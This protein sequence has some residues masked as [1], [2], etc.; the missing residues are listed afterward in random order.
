[1]NRHGFVYSLLIL[2]HLLVSCCKV[3]HIILE[4]YTNEA[5]EI[6]ELY[7]ELLLARFGL[8]EQMRY[9]QR[10]FDSFF[11]TRVGIVTL[12]LPKQ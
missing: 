3:E 4:D 6:L 5:L 7:C 12:V 10:I 11:L 9:R 1:M 8:L 2:Y